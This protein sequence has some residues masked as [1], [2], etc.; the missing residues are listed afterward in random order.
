MGREDN[1]MNDIENS[2]I[3][4]AIRGDSDAFEKIVLMYEKKVYNIAF[5]M[6]GNEHD[7]YDSSQEVFIKL[8]KN[9]HSFK[10]DSSFGT[11]LY[12]IAMNTCIDEYRKKKRQN[13]QAYSLDEPIENESSNIDRQLRDPAMTPEQQIVQLEEVMRI[14]KAIGELKEDHRAIVILRDIRGHSYDEISEI[15]HCSVGTVKSRLSRARIALRD[16]II[17]QEGT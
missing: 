13:K 2:L 5:N 3:K 14:R 7:A 6:F 4:K 8:Y 17:E 1:L 11:W 10:F 15:L 16:I 9:I 12:R